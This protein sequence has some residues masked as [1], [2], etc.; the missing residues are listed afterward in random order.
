MFFGGTMP[1]CAMCHAAPGQ[2]GMPMMMGRMGMMGN[3]PM[4]GGMGHGPM[5]GMMGT[6]PHLNGQHAAYIADELNEFATG[7]RRSE[8]MNRIA[9]TLGETDRKS[10]AEYLSGLR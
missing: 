5:M 4:M 10:V 6:A 9:S 7:E 3:M 8:I 1:P 2:R